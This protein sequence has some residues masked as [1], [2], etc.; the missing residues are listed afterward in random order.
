MKDIQNEKD[1]V[2]ENEYVLSRERFMNWGRKSAFQGTRLIFAI[3]WCIMMVLCMIFALTTKVWQGTVLG[4]FCFY[5]GLIRWRV[6]INNQYN[7]LSKQHGESNWKRKILFKQD[8][9]QVID[10]EVLICYNYEDIV[11]IKELGNE[12]EIIFN[13]GTVI[14]LYADTFLN[15]NWEECKKFICEKVGI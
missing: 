5:R 1:I 10:K 14:R 11:E 6:L 3:F 9:I 2:Y 12:I 15:S 7:M 4:L 8:G 13:N